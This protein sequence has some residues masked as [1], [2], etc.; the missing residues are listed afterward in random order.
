[1][2]VKTAYCT[3]AL[4]LLIPMFALAQSTRP[5]PAEFTDPETHLRIVH[6]STFPNARSGVIYFTYPSFTQDSQFALIDEQFDNKWR[7]LFS[8]DF[9][10]QSVHPLVTDRLTQDQVVAPKTG[11]LY[12][13]ADNAAWVT[14]LRGAQPRKIADVPP[15]WCPGAGF[16]VNADETLLVGASSDVEGAKEDAPQTLGQQKP[17]VLFTINI[18]TGEVKVIHRINTW[19]GHVQF[20]PTD[21][22]LMM[23]CHE[24]NWEKVD[25]IWMLRLSKGEPYLL[26]KRAE[27]HEIV[28][29]EFWAP[30]GKTAWFQQTFRDLKKSYLT[31]QNLET[32]KLTQYPVP[33]DGGSIHY[34]LSPDGRFFVGD[35]NGK[36]TRGPNKYLSILL[37]QGDHLQLI[38]VATLQDNDYSIEPNPHVSPDN[39]WIIFTATLFGTPQAY[40]VEVPES[41][42]SAR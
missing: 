28:G 41:L 12:Y 14:N 3:F 11:N 20:S 31:G 8:Y 30:D 29:H 26:Y 27:P 17:N 13:L 23:F 16:S 5:I 9:K 4:L 1:M 39:K 7:H 25:R 22:D 42:W 34:T 2:D 37:P 38:H 18:K 21:P 10:T 19:L 6:L 24:G 36:I 32:G 33:A 35:G 40:G 15:R